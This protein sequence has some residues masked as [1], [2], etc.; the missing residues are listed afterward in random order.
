MGKNRCMQAKRRILRCKMIMTT[1]MMMIMMP[2]KK[3][4]TTTTATL[5]TM[6]LWKE[7]IIYR[8]RITILA[9]QSPL[10]MMMVQLQRKKLNEAKQFLAITFVQ[11]VKTVTLQLIGF[12]IVLIRSP[13]VVLTKKR[14]RIEEYMILIRRK[15]LYQD[16]HSKQMRK[17]LKIFSLLHITV[18]S[19]HVLDL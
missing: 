5:T 15:Y 11:P 13:Y 7:T 9:R 14:K 16:Y 3:A 12:M 4:L 2:R 6:R 1:M 18:V 17:R 19:Y 10:K 8:L